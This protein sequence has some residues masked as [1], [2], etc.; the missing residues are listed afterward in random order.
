M[1]VIVGLLSNFKKNSVILIRGYT[2]FARRL[3]ADK[4]TSKID[5]DPVY[6]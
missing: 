4:K 3:K 2:T 5:P 1:L 6:D